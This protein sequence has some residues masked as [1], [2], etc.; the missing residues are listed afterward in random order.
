MNRTRGS[1][2]Q[3]T[4]A[5]S[6]CGLERL[7]TLAEAADLATTSTDNI[8]RAIR[9][10]RLR[11][12]NVAGSGSIRACWRIKPTDLASWIERASTPFFSRKPR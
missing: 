3:H 8:R 1:S 2:T 10:G 5:E 7:L 9:F 4:T 12:S 11:A 6:A